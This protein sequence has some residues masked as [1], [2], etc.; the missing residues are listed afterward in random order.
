MRHVE[1]PAQRIGE[2]VNRPNGC[3]GESL[4]RD[5]C[6]D[7]HVLARVQIVAARRRPHERAPELAQRR[8]RQ[9]VRHGVL[10][11]LR[12]VG[13]DGVHHGVDPRRRRDVRGQP[14]S[15]LR[16]QQHPVGVERVGHNPL[17]GR[18]ARRDD[19]DVCDFRS[20]P[21]RGGDQHQRQ[22]RPRHLA[23]AVHVL[24]RL[25]RTDE[26]ADHLGRVHRAPAP[27]PD[28]EVGSEVAHEVRAFQDDILRRVGHH[29]IEH[30]DRVACIFQRRDPRIHQ[31]EPSH[32]RIRDNYDALRVETLHMRVQ[33]RGPAAV[34]ADVGDGAEEM[35]HF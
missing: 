34:D 17:L 24:D 5:H 12:G 20:C 27:E 13:L 26:R 2:P 4:S 16:I 8:Q 22:A 3:V 6:P 9:R 32:A 30:R 35:G 31:A 21:R 33:P 29:L 14:A 7:Q 25:L 23:H 18:L 15:Q 19:G 28:D 1:E 11:M 10:L